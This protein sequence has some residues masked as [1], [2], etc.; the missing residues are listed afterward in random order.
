LP[1][2]SAASG[3]PRCDSPILSGDR[4][5]GCN[6][7]D[8]ATAAAYLSFHGDRHNR[9]SQTMEGNMPKNALAP[10]NRI[11]RRR[12]MGHW[13]NPLSIDAIPESQLIDRNTALR[14]DSPPGIK[15]LPLSG[16]RHLCYVLAAR[17]LTLDVVACD[18]HTS[19][20][21]AATRWQRLPSGKYVRVR[22]YDAA[23][24]KSELPTNWD[25]AGGRL[26]GVN[27][28]CD[29]YT[30]EVA[31][32][33]VLTHTP[34]GDG[35]RDETDLRCWTGCYGVGTKAARYAHLADCIIAAIADIG[36]I[37]LLPE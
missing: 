27:D 9:R 37:A 22:S 23:D 20:S 25:T 24:S 10:D 4:D 15:L 12:P 7:L 5:F 11:R 17:R 33:D 2:N 1:Q 35:E 6:H 29:Y 34:C 19:P 3:G 28:G 13:A 26:A 36:L 32:A 21:L 31:D 30:M 14:V 18:Q 8:A 16:D